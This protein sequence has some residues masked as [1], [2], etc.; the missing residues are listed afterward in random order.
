M[1]GPRSPMTTVSSSFAAS[2]LRDAQAVSI[3]SWPVKKIKMW[4]SLWLLWI[5]TTTSTAAA[6]Y[7][8]SAGPKRVMG[9]D[10]FEW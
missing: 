6:T 4:P 10:C 8:R 9:C 1:A 5:C 3:S 7:R 2:R